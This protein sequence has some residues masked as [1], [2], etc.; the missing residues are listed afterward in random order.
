MN[1]NEERRAR[2]C[3]HVARSVVDYTD[4]IMGKIL[5]QC[6]LKTTKLLHQHIYIAAADQVQV[7]KVVSSTGMLKNSDDN[8][9][10]VLS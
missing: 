5:Q 7:I 1:I 10:I 3:P 6:C 4:I 9:K 2:D 8:Y